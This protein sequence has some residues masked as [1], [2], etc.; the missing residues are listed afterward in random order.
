MLAGLLLTAVEVL[1]LV[2]VGAA[3]PLLPDTVAHAAA[4]ALEQDLPTLP[5]TDLFRWAIQLGGPLL[6]LNVL[7]LMW[8]R[9]DTKQYIDDVRRHREEYRL[10]SDRML[11]E[12][13]RSTAATER[14][15]VA[16]DRLADAVEHM[17][18]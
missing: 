2:R 17:G 3:S 10:F 7:T 12:Q 5:N 11:V 4:V 15:A 9:R 13:M 6:G 8:S 16:L 1:L 14:H 18:R